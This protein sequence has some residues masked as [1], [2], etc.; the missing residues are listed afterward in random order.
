MQITSM[1]KVT[2]TIT[3]R[4]RRLQLQQEFAAS[5]E[6]V[7]QIRNELSVMSNNHTQGTNDHGDFGDNS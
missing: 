5:C 1:T 2:I 6:Q 4:R 7:Q 3:S